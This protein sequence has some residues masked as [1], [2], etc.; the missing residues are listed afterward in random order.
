MAAARRNS[1]G[2]SCCGCHL[3]RDI[4]RPRRCSWASSARPAAEH[5]ETGR[6][7]RRAAG[8]VVVRQRK[9]L[10]SPPEVPGGADMERDWRWRDRWPTVRL[11]SPG[12]A[13][14]F[15]AGHPGRVVKSP[16]DKALIGFGD[17]SDR[18][19]GLGPNWMREPPFTGGECPGISVASVS[20]SA[21]TNEVAKNLTHAR[22]RGLFYGKGKRLRTNAMTTLRDWILRS[23]IYSSV[24]ARTG[25]SSAAET[26]EQRGGQK[27]SCSR[28]R[29]PG[30]LTPV[31]KQRFQPSQ[32][33][34]HCP[35]LLASQALAL[36]ARGTW[37]RATV[38][39][40]PC[41]F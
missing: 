29:S 1:G 36:P 39:L 33:L 18:Q 12:S 5:G 25:R 30:R 24:Q 4:L 13:A 3:D 17:G 31:A 22:Q 26:P 14:V 11:A 40:P 28:E 19:V 27:G 8:V 38:R 10:R 7:S 35:R 15:V 9:R 16:K 23:W 37:P 20:V 2:R 34:G 32:P 21:A 6:S 41:I